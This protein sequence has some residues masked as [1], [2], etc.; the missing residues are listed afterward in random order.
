MIGR[1]G[2]LIGALVVALGAV[3][4]HAAAQILEGRPITIVVPFPPGASSDTLMRLV[5]NTLNSSTGQVFVIENKAGAGGAIAANSVKQAPP[6]GHTLLQANIGSHAINPA[7]FSALGYD[8]VKDFAPITVMWN[9]PSLLVVPAASPAKSVAELIAYAKTKSAGL[10]FGSQGSGSGGHILGEILKVRTGAPFVHVPF[11][12]AAPAIV[13]LV[14]GRIDL[15]FTAYAS[16]GTFMQSG[17][18][19]ALAVTG[20]HRLKAVPN[21]P[22]MAEAGVPGVDLDVWFGLVAPAGTPKPVID[23]LHAAFVGVLKSPA[24]ISQMEGLGIEAMTNTPAEFAAM[25][26][27]D[28]KR[29]VEVV[30]A[31]GIKRQ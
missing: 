19:R 30:R 1:A 4:P 21:I 5:T 13:D 16:V 27:A 11:R 8:S 6:D 26:E 17:K 9:F 18:L 23:K 25:I 29:M 31:A 7:L 10:N 2:V 3:A 24:I 14:A 20:N 12:G 28:G 15:L 22:T